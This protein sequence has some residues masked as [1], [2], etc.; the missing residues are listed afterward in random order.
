MLPIDST[1]K[2]MDHQGSALEMLLDLDAVA[3]SSDVGKGLVW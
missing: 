3:K 1:D 2:V